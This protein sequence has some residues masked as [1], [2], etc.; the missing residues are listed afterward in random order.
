MKKMTQT[1]PA[2]VSWCIEW[3]ICSWSYWLGGYA[4]TMVTFSLPYAP[5]VCCCCTMVGPI[6]AKLIFCKIVQQRVLS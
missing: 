1:T 6:F 2:C 5:L 4:S 3:W